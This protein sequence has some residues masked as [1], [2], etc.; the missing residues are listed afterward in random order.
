M[1]GIGGFS[2]V[3]PEPHQVLIWILRLGRLDLATQALGRL[4][5]TTIFKTKL[6]RSE[7]KQEQK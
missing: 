4:G 2:K 6:F 5:C 3:T 7:A 1:N